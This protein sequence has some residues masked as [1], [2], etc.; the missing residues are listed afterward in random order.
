MQRRVTAMYFV[1]FLVLGAGAYTVMAL[2]DAPTIDVPGETYGNND[3]F[4]AGGQE[5]TVTGLSESGGELAY[6]NESFTYSATLTNNSTVPAAD[7]VWS[8]Q[9][10]RSSETFQAGSTIQYNGS[11]HTVQIDGSNVTF[12]GDDT[13]ESF[14]EGDT[15]QY[16]GN[17][18]TVAA[19]E[20]DTSVTLA[21]GDS[22]RVIIAN[23][24]DVSSFTFLQEFNVT[25]RLQNDPAVYN[26]T[27]TVDGEPHVTYRENNTN[28]PLS[29][30]LPEPE[31]RE[32][33]EGDDL[34]YRNNGTTVANVSRS[35]VTLEWVAPKN[36]TIELSEG[37]NVTLADDTQ[38]FAH[39]HT[40]SGEPRVTIAET[41]QSYSVYSNE[42]GRQAYFQERMN[43]LW[44]V[45][46]LSAI[47]AILVAAMALM[48]VK[49]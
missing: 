11:Q 48:P 12:Q 19:V 38:Y 25:N 27:T 24:S 35:E 43:G 40:R 45:V 44:G 7:V 29:E 14:A 46:I 32:V 1:L 42:L 10:A 20:P 41:G 22:Y 4:R 16:R 18:T 23:E 9:R 3:T 39:F 8:G 36:Q 49:G 30:Y 17:N 15:L 34:Q 47:A 33:A 5:Y 28:R 26:E 2:A 31:R 21:W 6:T 37:G 13:N